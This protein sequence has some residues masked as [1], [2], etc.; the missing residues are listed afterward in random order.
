MFVFSQ[1][2]DEN[3]PLSTVIHSGAFMEEPSLPPKNKNK[4]MTY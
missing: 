2:N 3:T 1:K 4:T